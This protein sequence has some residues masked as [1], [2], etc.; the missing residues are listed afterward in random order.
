MKKKIIA[1]FTLIFVLVSFSGCTIGEHQ[2]YFTGGTGFSNVFRIGD[3]KCSKKEALLYLATY[4]NLYGTV[5]ET[6]LWSDGFQTDTIEESIKAGVLAHLTRVYSLNIYAEENGIT[7]T[8]NETLA[9]QK[10]A[11][12]Y[13][14]GLEKN[15]RKDIG[16]KE[17]DIEKIY[18]RYVLAEKVYFQLMDQVDEEVSED[19]ARIMDA[20]VL[21][22]TSQENALTVMNALSAGGSFETLLGT[23]GEGDKTL[24]SIGRGTY[25]TEVEDVIFQ[26]DDEEISECIQTDEGYYFVECVDKYNEELSE[27]NKANVISKRKEQVIS[28]MISEQN[29]NYYS[30]LNTRLWENLKVD[31]DVV[32]SNFFTVLENYISY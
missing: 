10:A 31:E 11:T 2:V 30:E 27:T 4:K 23:Y 28:D 9:A 17:S 26:L 19:E 8:E 32:T 1:V 24:Q 22:T 7:L 18:E 6:S 12:E 14:N 3:M 25:S 13:F 21:F 29:V 20:Y 16:V 5:G 15:D